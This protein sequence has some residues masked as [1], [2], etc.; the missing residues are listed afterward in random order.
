MPNRMLANI[1]A[2]ADRFSCKTY[3]C[4][5]AKVIPKTCQRLLRLRQNCFN[6]SII[7]PY[8]VGKN[9]YLY[10]VSVPDPI[11]HKLFPSHV[12]PD[13]A[14]SWLETLKLMPV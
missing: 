9:E 10:A 5:A 12:I 11:T 2:S 6:L 8:G 3:T 4:K 7:I 14:N 13:E 1:I